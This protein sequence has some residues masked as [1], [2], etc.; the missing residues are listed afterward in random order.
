MASLLGQVRGREVH[1][2][3]LGR[4]GQAGR[5]QGGAHPLARFGD[6][7]V[8]QADD[9]ENDVSGGNLDLDVDRSRLDALKR[10]RRHACDHACPNPTRGDHTSAV[11]NAIE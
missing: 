5:D 4:Q 11:Q 10:D 2:N 7:L 6:G 3:A 8:G 1:G 9:H